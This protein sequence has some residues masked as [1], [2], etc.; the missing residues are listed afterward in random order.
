MW[1]HKNPA[2]FLD[3]W[4]YAWYTIS[5][6]RVNKKDTLS[7]LWFGWNRN[8]KHPV[9]VEA[10]QQPS[11]IECFLG[12][13]LSHLGYIVKPVDFDVRSAGLTFLLYSL[14]IQRIYRTTERTATVVA[15]SFAMTFLCGCAMTPIAL[16]EEQSTSQRGDGKSGTVL[17]KD[18]Y[19]QQL[20]EGC[21][22]CGKT[23][24]LTKQGFFNHP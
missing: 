20:L 14:R 7:R 1:G 12:V 23:V 5:K 21:K 13:I 15:N 11:W 2:F 22:A 6:D 17:Y 19:L 4:Y 8:H 18:S 3:F 9:D 10:Q 16:T 24:N